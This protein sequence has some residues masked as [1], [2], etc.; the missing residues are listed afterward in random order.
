MLLLNVQ[1]E[2]LL[3]SPSKD[4]GLPGVKTSKIVRSLNTSSDWSAAVIEVPSH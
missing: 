1:F 2:M 4:N 3:R